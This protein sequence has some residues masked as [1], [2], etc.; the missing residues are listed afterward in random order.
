MSQKESA[1]D[2]WRV[3][4]AVIPDFPIYLL[5]ASLPPSQ[6]SGPVALVQ[7]GNHGRVQACDA[8]A[9]EHGI[10]PGL[11]A[12]QAWV[13]CPELR[14]FPWEPEQLKVQTLDLAE[15]LRQASPGI[16]PVESESGMFWIDAR[17]MR[18]MGGE[19][20]MAESL[21]KLGLEAGFTQMR[22][23][24]ADTLI[25][26]RAA[27]SHT[28]ETDP[29]HI[30][31]SGQDISFIKGLSLDELVIDPH[32]KD[33]L[34]SL[35]LTRVEELF[36]LPASTLIHRFG[37]AGLDAIDRSRG[38]D[39]RRPDER[40]PPETLEAVL[41]LEEP[42][43][44]ST[45][46]I[47]GLRSIAAQ[48]AGH[49]MSRSLSAD[50]LML[51]MLLD[52]RSELTE[53]LCP[54]RPVHHGESIF[55]LVRDRLEQPEFSALNSPV[56]EVRLRA[57]ETSPMSAQ[58]IHMGSERWDAAALERIMDRLQGRFGE[59]VIFEAVG[60]DDT[61]PDA[62][63]CWSPVIEVPVTEP[64]AHSVQLNALPPGPIRRRFHS[65]RHLR[66]KLDE[67]GLPCAI[68]WSGH[69]CLV[70]ARGPERMS[71]QWW[72]A[73]TYA[74]EDYRAVLHRSSVLW[75]RHDAHQASWYAMGWLD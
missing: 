58:Q 69:W 3:G 42:V 5:R 68:W 36:E 27:A 26:A 6:G 40:A 4:C 73:G 17:G 8:L 60:C 41:V 61:R 51:V 75:I 25:A 30:V 44:A 10:H 55:E 54:I 15:K 33:A 31:Q 56:V 43:A 63:G 21:I 67:D 65:P 49:L 70:D 39:Y 7:P 47:F 37:P 14:C 12:N 53:T 18:W 16:S 2:L 20:G 46:L 50:C 48:L 64:C 23:G 9:R 28:T 57:T 13:R 74:Y 19:R 45:Q 11:T 59:A 24:I 34:H 22:V 52:D 38:L 32:M 71:G 35:G 29:V 62:A 1:C 66:L 72:D